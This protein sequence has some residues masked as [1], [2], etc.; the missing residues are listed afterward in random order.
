ML[1][2]MPRLPPVTSAALLSSSV[3]IISLSIDTD[4]IHPGVMAAHRRSLCH[5]SVVAG[6]ESRCVEIATARASSVRRMSRNVTG[7]AA[8]PV[9]P[10]TQNAH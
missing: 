7:T 1:A 6:T 9:S 4:L 10:V 8:S 5:P 3:T 2:P